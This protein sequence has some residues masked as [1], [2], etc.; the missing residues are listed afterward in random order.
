MTS[1][2]ARRLNPLLIAGRPA[3][4]LTGL[5]GA[6]AL[7]CILVASHAQLATAATTTHGAG[8]PPPAKMVVV[9]FPG[10]TLDDLLRPELQYLPRL[11]HSSN[12]AWVAVW[13]QV[14]D[15]ARYGQ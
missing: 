12:A 2:K 4:M 8:P 7:V 1:A 13:R 11:V 6:L 14:G 10:I 9:S 5:G 15:P 3:N